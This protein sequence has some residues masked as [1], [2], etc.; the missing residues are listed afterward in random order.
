MDEKQEVKLWRSVIL[1]A[2]GTGVFMLAAVGY[3]GGFFAPTVFAVGFMLAVI[4]LAEFG[5]ALGMREAVRKFLKNEQALGW[6]LAVF[7]AA[8]VAFAIAYFVVSW[9]VDL[10][11]TSVSN[12]YTFTGVTADAI[13]FALGIIGLSVGLGLFFTI[14]WLWV[15]VHRRESVYG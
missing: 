13:V 4:G 8:I 14:I 2:I 10:V 3:G 5:F 7:G 1:V 15:N 6:Q 9:Q 11:Y 12:I